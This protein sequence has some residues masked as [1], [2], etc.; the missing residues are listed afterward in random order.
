MQNPG[1]EHSRQRGQQVQRPKVGAG[2]VSQALERSQRA[3]R[4][5][6]LEVGA[7]GDKALCP[8]VSGGLGTELE[9]SGSWGPHGWSEEG[10]HPR[11]R[12]PSGLLWPQMNKGLFS[13]S[14][15]LLA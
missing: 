3:V 10:T 5:F 1:E 12:F 11:L 4:P 2:L 14:L 6:L 9:S 13:P 8:V 7:L 15:G